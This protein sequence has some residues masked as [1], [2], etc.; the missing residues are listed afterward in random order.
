[1]G[2]ERQNSLFQPVPFPSLPIDGQLRTKRS[3]EMGGHDSGERF[4]YG[5]DNKSLIRSSTSNVI[6][7]ETVVLGWRTATGS[8]SPSKQP[9]SWRPNP[10]STFYVLKGYPG[11]NQWLVRGRLRAVHPGEGSGVKQERQVGCKPVAG[12]GGRETRVVDGRDAHHQE[13][14][15]HHNRAVQE[16]VHDKE[17]RL[18]NLN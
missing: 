11:A 9:Q 18:L 6:I 5:V 10:G 3:D 4:V 15:G 13:P 1:M 2:R 14:R 8:A 7:D 17:G 16:G 12:S